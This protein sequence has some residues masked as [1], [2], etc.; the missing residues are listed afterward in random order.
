MKNKEFYKDK[1]FSAACEYKNLAVNKETGELCR[2][3]LGL[4]TNCALSEFK[5]GSCIGA[6]KLWLEQEHTEPLL[7][8]K[9]KNYLENIIRPFKDRVKFIRKNVGCT[10]NAFIR[11][12]VSKYDDIEY[13][14]FL[15]LPYFDG[16]EMYTGMEKNKWYTLEELGLF[17]DEEKTHEEQ[18]T[19]QG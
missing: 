4:C 13:P 11:I 8:A 3:Q 2:C 15:T 18:R 6:W 1:I 9:E 19:L 5:V 7:T 14:D 10:D 17:A 12:C 16:V